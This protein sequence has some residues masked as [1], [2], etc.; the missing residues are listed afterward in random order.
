MHRFV[1]NLKNQMH[2]IYKCILDPFTRLRVIFK[3]TKRIFWIYRNLK[4]KVQTGIS[5]YQGTVLN[6]KIYTLLNY[7]K[8]TRIV[9]TLYFFGSQFWNLKIL[10]FFNLFI[11]DCPTSLFTCW[12]KM[13]CTLG[14]GSFF[15]FNPNSYVFLK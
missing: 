12:M 9:W 1:C 11:L 3:V 4:T 10:D 13:I 2:Y 8:H 6:S 7:Q 15:S 5:T 14:W